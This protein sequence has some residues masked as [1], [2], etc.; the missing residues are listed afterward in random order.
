MAKLLPIPFRS[1]TRINE[2]MNRQHEQMKHCFAW[3]QMIY[4]RTLKFF[5]KGA[6]STLILDGL[7]N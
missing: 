3:Y 2:N 6:C 1:K 5:G 4:G 7:C